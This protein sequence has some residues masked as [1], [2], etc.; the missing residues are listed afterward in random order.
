M[1]TILAFER[2]IESQ[3]E[4]LDTFKPQKQIN[5]KGALFCGSGDSLASSMMAECFSD[6]QALAVDP[7]V[8]AKN[9]SISKNKH[10]YFV[11]ISGNTISNIRA[12]K[13]VK[14]STAITKNPTSN[15]AKACT[16][17]I[18]LDY[19]DSGVMTSGSISFLA[20]MLACMSLVF[21]FRVKNA[22]KLFLSAKSQAR[23]IALKNKVYFIGNQ[24]T[25]PLCMYAAAK[26]HEVLGMDA[27]YDMI[28]QFSHAGLFSAKPGD[29]V[30]IFEGKNAHNA[31]LVSQLKSLGLSVHTPSIKSGSKISQVIFY[32]FV[33]QVLALNGA[34]RKR[35]TDCYFITEKKIRNVSSSMIY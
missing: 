28:E 17:T 24:H 30:I 22:R 3:L 8:L 34:K 10:V 2:D 9:K 1:R 26:L 6:Y 7:L 18:P 32:T 19:Y 31:C 33:S 27:H 13:M 5:P 23:K 4:F 15:L 25:Y 12:A 11:S 29:T 16:D 35:L 21:G 14:K 20:S